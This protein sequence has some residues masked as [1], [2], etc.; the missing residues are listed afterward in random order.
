MTKVPPALPALRADLGLTLVESGCIADHAVHASA[1]SA[2]VFFGAVADRFGQK[3]FA[4]AGLALMVAGGLLGAAAPGYAALLASRFL[5]GVGF[6]L[7]VVAGRAAARRAPTQPA[8]RAT[9]FSHLE[10]VHAD[11]RHAGAAGGAA[12]ARQLRLAQPAGSG[13]PPTRR[14]AP[15]CWRAWCRRR[16]SAAAS[17]RCGCWPNRLRARAAWRCASASSAT[18]ASGTR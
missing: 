6:M 15:S 3:R 9:A 1:R 14:C 8:D 5:E 12:R 16:S 4:L 2:G 10:L 11:R 17:A 7:F 18:S 13:S